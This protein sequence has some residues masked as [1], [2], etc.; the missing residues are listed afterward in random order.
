MMTSATKPLIEPVRISSPMPPMAVGRP[1]TMPAKMMIE[2]PLP[3]PRSVICSPS[4][5]RNMVPVTSDTTVMKRNPG[6]GSSTSPGC[7]SSATAMPTAWKVASATVNQRV[8][9]VISRRPA[10]PSFFFASR[11]GTTTVSS[12][13]M[14]EAEM[15]GMIPSA[16][17][18]KRDSAPP[19]KRLNIPRMPPCWPWNSWVSWF[20]SM[21]G[22]GMCAPTR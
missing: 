3:R 7:A 19:E 20:G 13:M 17:T 10:S 4:H 2:M 1:A 18:V 21:P 8:Y 14:I 16:N 12:C 11:K 22:T 5:I 9:L 6:P 15:Y